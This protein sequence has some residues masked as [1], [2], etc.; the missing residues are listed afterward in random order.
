MRIHYP[1]PPSN[2]L[3]S[4]GLHRGQQRAPTAFGQ[5]FLPKKSC[6]PALQQCPQSWEG[7]H[8]HL[9]SLGELPIHLLELTIYCQMAD[10][11]A[12]VWLWLNGDVQAHRMWNLH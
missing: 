3:G 8:R 12:N 5:L 11:A 7:L 9:I 1:Y 6:R 2:T 10:G 4:R